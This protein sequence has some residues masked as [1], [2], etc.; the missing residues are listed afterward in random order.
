[1]L[2]LSRLLLDRVDGELT[3]EQEKQVVF[4]RKEAEDLSTLVNDLLDLA[5]IEAGK[6]VVHPAEFEVANLFSA[7]RGMLKPLLINPAVNLVFEE[8]EGIRPMMTD[9][10]KVS[11][12]LRNFISN[13]IKFTERGEIRVSARQSENGKGVIFSV[14]DTGIGIAPEYLDKIFEEY[15]QVDT[16]LLKKAKGTGLGLSLSK[17][18]AELLG[19]RLFVES[20]PGAGSVFSATIPAVYSE[21]AEEE[22]KETVLPDITRRQVMVI[23][24]DETAIALY[25]KY[26]RGTGFQVLPVRT[27][28][29]ARRRLKEIIP[30]AV[31]LD[32][33]LK[34]EDGWGFYVEMKSN[35]ATREIPVFVVTVLDEP[36]KVFAFGA[37][38]FVTKPVERKW[39]L[40]K[41]RDVAKHKPVEKVLIIDDEEVARYILKGILADTKYTVFEASG[42]RAGLEIAEQEMP[43]VVFLDLLMPEMDGFETLARLKASAKTQDIPVIIL[44]AKVLD[45]EERRALNKKTIATISKESTSQEV[46]LTKIR[47]AI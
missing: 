14:S 2:S 10:G 23:E 4:I 47:N 8:S 45:E 16:P 15:A 33:L 36:D 12:I 30:A 21:A 19:G 3:Q 35:D 27:L 6:I 39:L 11:Q 40:N 37:D 25:E 38:D 31:I 17:K 42:G 43:D 5:K 22:I 24:D 26:F 44:T 20:A 34:G 7:L 13:S 32:I 46:T 18:L 41:L 28:K 29:E 9:E 1:M